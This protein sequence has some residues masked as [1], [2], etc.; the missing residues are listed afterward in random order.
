MNDTM[1]IISKNDYTNEM[2]IRDETV[3]LKWSVILWK[4]I[5]LRIKLIRNCMRDDVAA[6][7]PL[8]IGTLVKE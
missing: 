7:V 2:L 8:S 4:R 3:C 6:D 1:F 5:D